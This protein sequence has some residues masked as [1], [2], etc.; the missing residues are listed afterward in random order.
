MSA[1]VMSGAPVDDFGFDGSAAIDRSKIYNKANASDVS[2]DT[3]NIPPGC[4]TSY[5]TPGAAKTNTWGRT[6]FL[7]IG[8]VCLVVWIV[9][10][11]FAGLHAYREYTAIPF[12][13]RALR[14]LMAITFAPFYLY[15]LFMRS[16]TN[17]LVA[18]KVDLHMFAPPRMTP[19]NYQ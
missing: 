12:W 19:M 8:F 18:S 14:V 16:V 5:A 13:L 10:A 9:S 1:V 15:Y 17:A 7:V 4:P 6:L 2:A 3:E 11:V